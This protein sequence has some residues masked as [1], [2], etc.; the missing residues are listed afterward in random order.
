[1]GN[2]I[3]DKT[4]VESNV[5]G[6]DTIDSDIDN[7]DADGNFNT[8]TIS[9]GEGE[10]VRDVDAGVED[11]GTASVG[12]FVFFDNND[13]GIFNAGDTGADG[14]EVKLFQ[15]LDGDGT[16][17]TQISTQFT[18]N[19]GQYL[20]NN[21]NAGTYAVM[22]GTLAGFGFTAEGAAADDAVNNDSD[23]G[24]LDG[25]TDE[26]ILS[27]GEAER[28]VDAGLVALNEDP[29]PEPDVIVTCAEDAAA[30]MVLDNDSDPDGDPLSIVAVDGQAFDANGQVTT[31]NG[32]IV[33]LL[34]DPFTGN[35]SLVVDG[36]AAYEALDIDE[37]AVEAISYTV[38][39]G[40]GNTA[41]TELTVTFKGDANSVQSISDSLPSDL[42]EYQIADGFSGGAPFEDFGYDIQIGS[43]GGDLRF[44]G[45]EFTNAYCLDFLDPAATAR[46]FSGATNTADL[47]LAT[48]ADASSVFETSQV[49]IN[50]ETAADNLDLITW[51]LNQDFENTGAGSV[52]GNFTGWEVQF[53]IWEL[54]NSVDSDLTFNA[55]PEVGQVSDVDFIVQQ[56]LANGEGFEAGVGDIVGVILDPNP[57]TATN[58]QPFIVG[59]EFED[60]DCLCPTD[61]GLG[62][63]FG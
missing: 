49:G 10:D 28:D 39:D 45:I 8:G 21:L 23:A 24:L 25:M 54:T 59:I 41:T 3:D 19:G 34:V 40:N 11:P 55:A 16:A 20:F 48:D 37:T 57:A 26:F 29:E 44:E 62:G 51:I 27:I 12:N 15:D 22:F 33:S 58:S 6:D 46:D 53:A 2:N 56:A 50:G 18:S 30:V 52:D 36:S 5:G 63:P 47:L 17:E 13:D 32:T 4:L 61:D 43:A 35:V 14:V 7:T 31:A 9:L 1:D 42:I 38:D 60:L